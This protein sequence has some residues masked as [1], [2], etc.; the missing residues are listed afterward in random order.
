M[1]AV[2]AVACTRKTASAPPS[3]SATPA[4][5]AP[6]I[7]AAKPGSP[8]RYVVRD[9]PVSAFFTDVGFALSIGGGEGG[10]GLHWTLVGARAVVPKPKGGLPGRVHDLAE[11]ASRPTFAE[12]VYAGVYPGVTLTVETRRH[13]LAY[14]FDVAPGADPGAIRMRYEGASEVVVEEEGKAVRVRAGRSSLREQGL[15]CFQEHAGKPR[16]VPCKYQSRGTEIGVVVG[17]YD[18]KLPLVIDPEIN[19]S[20]YLGGSANDFSVDLAVDD[21][22]NVYLVGQTHSF[23]F[24]STGG[25]DTTTDGYDAF[26]T[27]VNA[28]GSTLAWSSYLGGSGY[29]F[30]GG[31][32]VDADGAV[33]VAGTTTSADFPTGGGFDTTYGGDYDAFVTKVDASGSSLTWSSYLGGSL[34]DRGESLI[35]DAGKNAYVVGYTQSPDFPSSG[36]FDTTLGSVQDAFV[37]KVD[38]SGSSLAW[39][40][41]LGGSSS[42][43]S[44]DDV[45]VDTGGNVYVTGF[46]GSD[47][48]PTMGGFDTTYGGRGDAFVTKID[49]AGSGLTWSSYLGGFEEEYG[50]GVAV[51]PGG[52]V[53]VVGYTVSLD[54]PSG[55]GFDTTYEGLTDAFVTKV[56]ASGWSL[57][58][59][60]YLGGSGDESSSAVAVDAN[61]NVYVTGYTNSSD[62]PSS[63]GFDTTYGG[64]YDAF[65][66][67]VD[68]SGS[69]LA[70]SSYL[71]RSDT[72]FG[73]SV[74]VNAGGNVHVTGYTDSSDFPSSGGFDTTYG[75]G[76]DAFVLRTAVCGD[77]LCEPGEN[78][79]TCSADCP[80]ACCSDGVCQVGED[81]ARCPWDCACAVTEFCDESSVPATCQPRCGDGT[82]DAPEDCTT[83]VADCPCPIGT[84]CDTTTTP[85]RCSP[86][87]GNGTCAA[88]EDCDNCPADCPC[89]T[90]E[91]C[92]G[93]TMP[94]TC[95][96]LCGNG[97]C[98]PNEHCDNCPADCPCAP[99]EIC[100]TL[101]APASCVRPETCGDG[102]CEDPEDCVT[103]EQDC[104]QCPAL[105]DAGGDRDGGGGELRPAARSGCACGVGETPGV[106]FLVLLAL[107]YA[108]GRSSWRSH[109]RRSGAQSQE[110][111]V[112]RGS[113]P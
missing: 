44:G 72:D 102:F 71:G 6:G 12:L 80:G 50:R 34:D 92:D 68:A 15:R 21:S 97:T 95:E 66:T 107:G 11:G 64:S 41:Y 36:G 58:W 14:R 48:F 62:F 105:P 77:G 75:G 24:P 51:D 89:R 37:T 47:D 16:D 103:C 13:A 4:W 55:G 110:S 31:V 101:M 1:L 98:E 45:A 84:F 22:G 49:A 85:S 78:E 57:T 90:D 28:D 79:C 76:Y 43:E 86:V 112:P 40:S 111:R 30:A 46:T 81:C 100:D 38:A 56:D 26:V 106:S 63:G 8:A 74:A 5:N 109:R 3:R 9:G 27:K 70:W 2:L 18:Q 65:A 19:W 113:R 35:V 104:G 61:G 29:D 88:T 25:F 93:T 60:S 53:Y 94:A 20:S 96:P 52:N 17:S 32:A 69:S 23:D 10:W 67:K 59:S 83:C 99:G 73:T 42:G 87:C 33:Y 39:S 82:C 54:F 7:T 108:S 91:Y